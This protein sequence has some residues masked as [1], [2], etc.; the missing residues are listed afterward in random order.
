MVTTALPVYVQLMRLLIFSYM[1]AITIY[2]PI[3]DSDDGEYLTY[4]TNINWI[5]LNVYFGVR[6]SVPGLMT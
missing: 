5:M 4:F 6:H 3:D 1:L 2:R